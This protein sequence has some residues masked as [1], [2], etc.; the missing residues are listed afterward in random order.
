MQFKKYSSIENS[1][2]LEMRNKIIEYGFNR[3]DWVVQEKINGANY[4][5]WMNSE[6]YKPAKRTSFLT[7]EDDFNNHEFV[8]DLYNDRLTMLYLVIESMMDDLQKSSNIKMDGELE[9]VLYGEI[10]GGEY[11]HKDVEKDPKA[12]RVQKG[13]FYCPHNDFY[14]YDLK[15]NGW[16]INYDV[17]SEIMTN[18]GFLFAEALY[19]GDYDT[20]LAYPNEFQTTIPD[21]FDLPELEDNICEGVVL[22]P[23]HNMFFPN[24]KRVILKNKN[25]KFSEKQKERKH[26]SEKEPVDISMN[27]EQTEL[28]NN[29][30]SYITENKLRNVLSHIGDVND[31]M[32][33]KVAGLFM[34]DV[35]DD[36]SKDFT[37]DIALM[38]KSDFKVVQKN[39]NIK[40]Q[41]MVKKNFLNIIDS[42]F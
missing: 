4:S 36:A 30:C 12:K 18:C 28:Y 13:V 23:V 15:I 35:I 6:G 7:V 34:K 1:Y 10:F 25:D 16:F 14:A 39:V 42:N 22:K 38:S 21:K 33:G 9:A 26:I 2:R 41:E 31:K 3:Y 11:P 19:R 27:E 17:F 32:F 20:C 8:M 24:G 5:F 40:V 29:I 37:E